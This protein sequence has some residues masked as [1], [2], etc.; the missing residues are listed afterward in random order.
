MNVAYYIDQ[1]N[2]EEKTTE[3]FNRMNED[4]TSGAIDNGSVFYKEVGPTNVQPK[5]GMFNSTDVWNFTGTLIATSME[6]FL[7]AIKAVNKYSLAY[8]FYGDVN[9]DIF[10]LIGISKSTKI[11]TSTEQDQKEVYRIT[12]VK[13]ILVKDVSPSSIQKA[14]GGKILSKE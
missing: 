7:D 8:L 13:P 4:I 9:H 11:L 5:F 2:Q 1:I 10:A 3:L 12:G 6:T 14:I